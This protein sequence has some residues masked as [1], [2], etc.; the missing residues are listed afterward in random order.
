MVGLLNTEPARSLKVDTNTTA[1]SKPAPPAASPEDATTE[2]CITFRKP[3]M[4]DPVKMYPIDI[5]G[6]PG[7]RLSDWA[8]AE[9]MEDP[10]YTHIS[11]FDL[12]AENIQHHI[13]QSDQIVEIYHLPV[14][15]ICVWRGPEA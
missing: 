15:T 12:A 4:A 9:N 3:V 5:N 11:G 8:V 14:S 6:V 13:P 10:T 7:L 2:A 1:T